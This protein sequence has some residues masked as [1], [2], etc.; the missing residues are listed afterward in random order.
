MYQQMVI[1]GYLGKDPEQRYLPSGVPVTRLSV[2]TNYTYPDAEGTRIEVTTWFSVSVYG[3]KGEA[4]FR[5]LKKGSQVYVEGRLSPDIKT[6]G[7][8]LWKKEDGTWGASYDL[9]AAQVLFLGKKDPFEAGEEP[10]DDAF[11]F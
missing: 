9:N 6:G 5:Y 8:R 3:K 4:C 11:P 1:I 2:A 10:G 7:P